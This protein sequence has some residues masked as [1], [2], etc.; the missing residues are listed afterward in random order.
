MGAKLGNYDGST[1]LQ[2]FLARFETC[3]EYFEWGDSDK[4]FQRELV[5]LEPPGRFCEMLGNSRSWVESS[6]CLRLGS[7]A[8]TKSND[9]VPNCAVDSE[10]RVNHY[11][12]FIKTSVV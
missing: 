1:C 3:A 8:R 11:K 4:L 7:A 5:W 6:L 10:L 2:T 9:S 12:N